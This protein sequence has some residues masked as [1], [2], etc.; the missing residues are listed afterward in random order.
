MKRFA[1]GMGALALIV[2][3]P[4]PVRAGMML[5]PT[6]AAAGFK[7]TTFADG[8]PFDPATSAGPLGIAFTP[9]GGVM[10]TDFPG[11]VRVFPTDTD[12]QNAAAIAVAQN[13]GKSNAVGL[14]QMGGNIYMAQQ[15][16]N[17][18]VQM[19]ANGTFNSVLI[20]GIPNATGVVAANPINGHLYVSTVL[21]NQIFDVN[22][23]TKTKSLFVSA[24]ADGLAINATGTILYAALRGGND[25]HVVGYSLATGALVYDSGAIP[26]EVDGIA[27]GT[28]NLADNLF[29]NTNAG[30]L[31]QINLSTLT[32]TTIATG[33]SRGDFVTAD[34]NGTMLLTQTD[35]VLRLSAPSGGGI[36]PGGGDAVPEPASLTLLGIGFAGMAGYV[37][38]RRRTA[39]PTSFLSLLL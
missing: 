7:L 34:P 19:N 31:L 35:S 36:G 20:S 10:V 15:A 28:G 38:R 29:V 33:G 17:D 2:S 1:Y 11:N 3:L 8:F 5:T 12:G 26:G 4:A 21:D 13:F 25:E 30:T 32:T 9:S 23:F 16:N 18:L 6:A 27:I 14:A 24:Q 37:W 39:A 22:P